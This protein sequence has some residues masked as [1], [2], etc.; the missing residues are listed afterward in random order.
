MTKC[1]PGPRPRSDRL[2]TQMPF[3]QPDEGKF[4]PLSNGLISMVDECDF[5]WLSQIRWYAVK[6][7]HSSEE[8]F[9]ASCDLLGGRM[10]K[11]KI[12]MHRM[13]L[14]APNT[15]TVDHRNHNTLDNRRRNLRHATRSQQNANRR[16]ITGSSRYK[17]VHRRCDGLKWVAQIRR[18]NE[19]IHLGSFSTED[20]A[21]LAY[22]A[23]ATKLFGEFAILNVIDGNASRPKVPVRTTGGKSKFFGVYP[24]H[25][26]PGWVAQIRIN[27][28]LVRLGTFE[29]EVLAALAYND[30]AKNA[31]GDNAYQN[32][33]PLTT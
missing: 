30:A 20:E 6:A 22:N 29:T 18:G 33:I 25:Y 12:L 5:H 23:M 17:G 26:G 21:G 16:K 4:I 31:F 10:G 32:P 1:K 28:K 2:P 19:H 27:K 11:V 14:L 9:Y 13:I 8:V 7:D 15:T 24:Y 3:E